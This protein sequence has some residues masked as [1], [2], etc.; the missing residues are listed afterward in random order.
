V[1]TPPGL[2]VEPMGCVLVQ[3]VT[4]KGVNFQTGSHLL[5]DGARQILDS[6]A[7][8][9]QRHPK[10]RVEIG[11]HTDNTGPVA[12]NRELSLSRAKAAYEYLVQKGINHEIM[13]VKGYSS[14]EPV[15][16]NDSDQ[17]RLQNRRVEMRIV[18]ID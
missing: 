17:G 18:E 11:G 14:E 12:I 3:V 1:G 16:N 5:N 9:L 8:T 15:A 7:D 10:M 4:L 2:I 13:K 6:M